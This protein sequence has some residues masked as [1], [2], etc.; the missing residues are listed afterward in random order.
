MTASAMGFGGA[1]QPPSMTSMRTYGGERTPVTAAEPFAR[2]PGL[3]P[4]RPVAPID[5]KSFFR[6]AR[7]KLTHEQFNNFL[8]SIKRLNN[9][10]QSREDTLNEARGLFGLENQD[11]YVDFE[12]LLNSQGGCAAEE[13]I[14]LRLG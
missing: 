1:Y 7:G 3:S 2:Q 9:Q 13:N 12:N 10:Q 6:Q 11:L 4:E 5:G 8:A 14:C